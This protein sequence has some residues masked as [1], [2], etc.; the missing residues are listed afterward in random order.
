MKLILSGMN[1]YHLEIDSLLIMSFDSYI[2]EPFAFV[3]I[4]DKP[5][6]ITKLSS[7]L[8]DFTHMNNLKM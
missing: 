3:Q 1:I 8:I 7:A 2:T 6:C 5:I 4:V